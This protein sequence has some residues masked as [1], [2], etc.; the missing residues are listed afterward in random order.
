MN[1]AELTN[2]LQNICH[3]GHA[4]KQVTVNGHRGTSVKITD[5]AVEITTDERRPENCGNH[6]Q[7]PDNWEDC[8]EFPNPIGA[9]Q[10]V[11]CHRRLDCRSCRFY[12]PKE[13]KA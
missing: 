8:G 13:K 2:R 10:S 7:V 9:V 11:A 4:K 12:V 6:F 5:D 1:A 3:D